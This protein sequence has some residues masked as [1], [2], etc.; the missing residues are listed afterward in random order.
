MNEQFVEA[1]AVTITCVSVCQSEQTER[2][3]MGKERKV[4]VV[5]FLSPCLSTCVTFAMFLRQ[6][7]SVGLLPLI[8]S[9]RITL[10]TLLYSPSLSLPVP[11]CLPLS[12]HYG[13]C[14]I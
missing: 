7:I 12:L 2:K 5:C 8:A 10:I 3:R 9:H 13:L 1:V 6:N 14:Q 4:T 11:L